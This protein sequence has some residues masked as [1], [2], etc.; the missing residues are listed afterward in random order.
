MSGL[1]GR[2]CAARNTRLLGLAM[3]M[4]VGLIVLAPSSAHAS[5]CTDSWT[6]NKGGSWFTPGN[7]SKGVPTSA[8]E[9]CISE[10]GTYTVEMTQTNTTG[11]VSLKSL[12]IGGTS[13]TQTL[14]VGSSSTLNAILT[15][16]A[17]VAN[18]AQGALTLTNG[19]S[20]ANSVTLIGPV[21]SSGTLTVEQAHGG[22][23]T[24]QGNLTNTGTVAINANTA[25][26]SAGTLLSN[27]GALNVAEGKQLTASAGASITNATGGKILTAT[28]A[29][30]LQSGGTF[31]EGAGTTSG[32][33]P[34]VVDDGAL[35]Y[36]GSGESS[37][38]LH[39]KSSLSGASSAGQSLSI[40]STSTEHAEA[41]SATSFSNAG[42]ITLTNGDGSANN[43]TLVIS[44]G[45]L[46]NSGT[47]TS[48]PANGGARTIQGSIAN[49][50]TL[51]INANTSYNGKGASLINEGALN[52][53]EGKTL[54]VSNEGSLTNGS[55][56]KI[57]AAGSGVAQLEPGTSFTEGAGTTSGTKP[58]I[59][60]DGALS[61]TGA[62]A[63]AIALHGESN[64]LSGN[65]SSGQALSIESTSAEH[66]KAAVGA[67]FSNAGSI[68][69]T[70]GDGSANNATLVIASGS[71]S[72]SGT[73]TSQQANGGART[74][75]GNLTNTGTLAINAN[76]SYNGKGASLIN[77]GAL[78]IAEGKA[79]TASNEGSLTNGS[80]GKIVAAGSGVVQMEPGTS[81]TEGAGTT[82]GTKPVIVRDAALSYTGAGASAI[83]LHGESNT[84]SGNPV[85]GQSLSIESTSGEHAR[86][87]VAGGFTNAGSITLTNGDSAANN[88]SLVVSS[89][90]LLNSGTITTQPA[91]GGVRTIQ[92]SI[93]NT[94]TLALNA[95]TIDPAAS[96]TLMN[97]GAIDLAAGVSFSLQSKPAI[98][99][100]SGGAITAT[101]T[102]VLSQ[103][104][105]TFTQGLGKSTGAMPVVVDDG[106]VV[107]SDKGASTVALR[108][109]STL[110]GAI[111]KGQTLAIQS[112]C[113]EHAVVTGASFTNSGTLEL[114]NGDGCGNNATL[115]LG[116][117]TLENKGAVNSEVPHG[118]TRTIEG[119]LKNEKTLSLDAGATLKVTASY[120]QGHKGTLKSAV[121]SATSFGALAV[122]G[123]ATLDG[124]LALA[125]SKTFFAKAGNSFA[126]L[127][128]SARTGTF[129]KAKSLAVKKAPGLYYKP[130]YSATGVTL[131]VT[132]AT[133]IASPSEALP[134]STVTF[135]GTGYV[136]GDTLKLSFTDHKGAKT[137][138]PVVTVNGTGEFS[139]EFTIPAGAAVGAA[140]LNAKS[141]ETAVSVNGT[142]N[143]T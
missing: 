98:A 134:G 46:S 53:A 67:S 70:N 71:L 114:T 43:A 30:V 27:Q 23:R 20:S 11:T 58:V 128:S 48:Q 14:I 138:L 9:A 3:A 139:T 44:S 143:V 131:L 4:I 51:A 92:G 63:S 125:Q 15:T 111:S 72:N 18:G 65:L 25:Y 135:S 90:T 101:G 24:L 94:G 142:F 91:N 36:A 28:S 21:T 117:G 100:E 77:E 22:N 129:V 119:T 45:S 136:P 66:A 78:N 130:T 124:S 113:S 89:G 81:F 50:G 1:T 112:T 59:V 105:G 127:S 118:G 97:K 76:T 126:I 86:L 34:V 121:A 56:G 52:I 61:Y 40:E 82:S 16:T 116:G 80:G 26:N 123:S 103:I 35:V 68:T 69:L 5:G 6:N 10:N 39:G 83:A 96:P 137:V 104:G 93:T 37:I 13:G 55:G 47:L 12:T 29:D 57:V 87:T 31:T 99:N 8:D 107:Y 32:T 17:G 60:R 120:T 7:W 73:L 110:S 109:S 79:L 62:G 132:Q 95:T 85:A 102:G 64:T 106:A 88:A 115:N 140:K 49:T 122:G 141:T 33:K 108:G 42:S 2:A 19:D 133:L 54:T 38:A 74:I 41:T 75:Q 84:L